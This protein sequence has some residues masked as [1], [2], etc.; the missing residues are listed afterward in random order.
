[1]RRG[2]T[3]E[4]A[5]NVELFDAEGPER[6][7]LGPVE[8]HQERV[9]VVKVGDD[10]EHA[11]GEREDDLCARLK[12]SRSVGW[13]TSASTHPESDS[14]G[15]DVEEDE[16]ERGRQGGPEADQAGDQSE[17]RAERGQVAKRLCAEEARERVL[18]HPVRPFPIQGSARFL[19]TE[20]WKAT[21][22]R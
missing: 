8:E 11:K 17:H 10:Q 19:C 13:R 21:D 6:G 2:R 3:A 4:D 20:D 1:M 15:A 18:L 7:S 5:A 9:E 16:G 14:A 22:E 12:L